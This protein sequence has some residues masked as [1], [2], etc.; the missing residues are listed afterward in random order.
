MK[1]KIW[2][3]TQVLLAI[4]LLIFCGL[5]GM[6]IY[7]G[8]QEFYRVYIPNDGQSA[9]AVSRILKVHPEAKLKTP[10]VI[11]GSLGNWIAFEKNS[12]GTETS[13]RLDG[14]EL[15]EVKESNNFLQLVKFNDKTYY[16]LISGNSPKDITFQSAE[17]IEWLLEKAGLPKATA[18]TS[19][20]LTQ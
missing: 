19:V 6:A 15:I 18:R 8:W 20:P 10:A 3:E 7:S 17:F 5:L 11:A 9:E 14:I 13:Y 2:P 12:D 4:P 1:K 16:L